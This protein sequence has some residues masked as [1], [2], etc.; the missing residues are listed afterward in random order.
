MAALRR[1]LAEELE[2]DLLT[3]TLFVRFDFDLRPMGLERYWRAYYEVAI[4][5]TDCERLVLR[6]GA[7]MRALSGD[8]ALSL[9]RLSPYD[10]FA[11]F[12]HHR[13]ERLIR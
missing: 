1:E 7:E 5:G 10:S 12:M 2:L 6:E 3:A 11:L 8:D 13:R 9:P 4:G